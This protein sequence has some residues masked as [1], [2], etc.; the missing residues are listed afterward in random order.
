MVTMMHGELAQIRTGELAS[1]SPAYPGVQLQS[2]LSIA[3]FTLSVINTLLG[4]HTIGLVT[5]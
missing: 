1:A 4:K 5:I 2:L 3:T